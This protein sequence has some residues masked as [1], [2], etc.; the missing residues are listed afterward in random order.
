MQK[1]IKARSKRN[2][3]ML[4]KMK[5]R[6]INLIKMVRQ[7]PK[8]NLQETTF[9]LEQGG[10]RQQID[11]ALLRGYYYS[12]IISNIFKTKKYYPNNLVFS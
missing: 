9:M 8:K 3:M 11:T 1:R 2:A 12:V 7:N 6:S 10:V 4:R 5:R